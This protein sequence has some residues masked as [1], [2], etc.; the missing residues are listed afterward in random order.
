MAAHAMAHAP[1]FTGVCPQCRIQLRLKVDSN[2]FA[3]WKWGIRASG[4][5]SMRV[6]DDVAESVATEL[7]REAQKLTI[8]KDKAPFINMVHDQKGLGGPRRSA[9]VYS[10]PEAQIK[11]H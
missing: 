5:S 4:S 10:F 11:L 7:K 1:L 6:L 9:S 2:E 8:K 3:K